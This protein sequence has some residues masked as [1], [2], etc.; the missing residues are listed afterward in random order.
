M[1][2]YKNKRRHSNK[3][4]KDNYVSFNDVIWLMKDEAE[5]KYRSQ[6]YDINWPR[7]S[8]H[9]HRYAKY[10]MSLSIMMV[11]CIKQHLS[12]TWCLI[13]EKVKQH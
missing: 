1:L 7:Q 5:N 9:R 6:R 11:I 10:K 12:N 3:C 4:T 2:S 8:R 13:H